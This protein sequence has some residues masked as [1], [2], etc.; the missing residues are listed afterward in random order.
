MALPGLS[1]PGLGLQPSATPVYGGAAPPPVEQIA[2]REDLPP[3]SEW[4]FEAAFGQQYNIRLLSGQAELFG[5][6]LAPKQTYNLSGCK[7]AIFTWQGCQLEITGDAESEYS[8]K[9]TEYAVEWLNLHGMLETARDEAQ[10]DGGPRVLV[11]GPD[12]AG[13]SSLVRS[14]A[15]WAV[16]AGRTPTVVNLD[17]REGMLAPPGSL[18]AAAVASQLD[19]ENGY[20]IPPISGP[21]VTPI[22]TPLIYSYPYASSSEKPAVYKALLTRMALSVTNK[23]EEDATA[24]QSGIIIDTP[25][26]LNDPKSNYD[27]LN[28]IVSE[29][30]INLILSIGSEKLLNDLTRRFSMGK[31]PGES[32]PVLRISRPGGTVERDA[33]Y[34]KQLRMSQLR[35]YFFGNAKE[36]LNPHSHSIN[37]GELGIYRA[38]SSSDA[39]NTSTGF[40][41]DDDDYTPNFGTTGSDGDFE[42]VTPSA[43]MTGSLIAIKF[44]PASSDGDAVRDSAVMG[45]LYVA[46][47]DEARKKM[48]F[49][50]PHPQ[51]WGDRALVWGSWPEVVAD[52]LT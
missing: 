37:F 7:G 27:I 11:V 2:R 34:M 36:P 9:E 8:A 43:A 3:Q 29:F 40:G 20:G 33:V 39:S 52:L 12:H 38:K 46:E 24:K 45:F 14:V 16:K 35:Q 5:V 48:R 41:A 15:A 17:P 10:P 23:L 28:H 22:Q 51:R 31:A 1:L 47:V 25:G 21:T 19:V 44:C 32:V 26:S 6:E 30:N 4:R 50:A 42:K 18:T 49:L 13:K